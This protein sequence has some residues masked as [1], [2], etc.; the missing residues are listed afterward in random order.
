MSIDIPKTGYPSIDKPWLKF[1]SK[2]AISAPL[3]TLSLYE[4]IYEKNRNFPDGIAIRYFG[5]KITFREMFLKIES[6]S[7]A[8]ISAGVKP[9]D[10]VAVCLP[11]VPESVYIIYALN[12]I[13]AIPNMLDPRYNESLLEYCLE[14]APCTLL[15]TYDGCYEKFL[16]LSKNI[17]PQKIVSISPLISVPPALR[18]IASLKQKKV[19]LQITKHVLW[20]TFLKQA[21]QKAEPYTGW[22]QNDCCI[23]LHTGGTTGNPKGVML[24]NYSINAIAHQYNMLVAPQ[25]GESLLDIIPPF[26]SY[27]VCTSMHMPLSLGLSIEMIPKFDPNQFGDLLAKYKPNY[28]MGVPSFYESMLSNKKLQ[29]SDMSYLYSAACGGDSVSIPIEKRINDFLEQHHSPAHVD[30]GYGMSEMSATACVCVSFKGIH[31]P[32]S[33][34]IPFVNTVF[35]I[36]KQDS[37]E[38]CKY[39]E[40]GEIC[41]SGPGMMLGYLKNPELTEKT[42]RKHTDGMKWVHT[43]DLGHIS[44]EGFL[45]HDGRI[46]RMIVRYDGF[47]IYPSAVEQAI[48][49]SP[50]VQSC[51]VIKFSK[52]GLGTMPK[53]YIILKNKVQSTDKILKEILNYCH[54]DLAERSVPQDF[55][56][57]EQLPLTSMGKID[58]RALEDE[59]NK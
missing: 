43:G 5:S 35:K 6:V 53:A 24:S 39:G 59:T 58:Y 11:A 30:M 50:D 56:F 29:H 51:A 28:V 38:E 32:G 10:V 9:K 25:R 54:E 21:N 22:K 57:V 37:M 27:G 1:Y 36:I 20:N 12:R 19:K 7:N 47:K 45:F 23:I 17:C 41:I 4:Y 8:F 16:R 52:E 40:I 42:I 49:K 13:G 26:A 46:K 33:I 48:M 3:P 34:G 55:E 15:L 44:K 2:E 31:S 14:E 18:F